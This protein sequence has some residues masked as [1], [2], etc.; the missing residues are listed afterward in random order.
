[1]LFILSNGFSSFSRVF[2]AS[3]DVSAVSFLTRAEE[4]GS[5][6]VDA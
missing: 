4:A 1:M 6:F 2:V 3:L 5:K